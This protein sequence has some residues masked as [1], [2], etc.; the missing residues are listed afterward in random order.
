[1]LINDRIDVHLAAGKWSRFI[2][3]KLQVRKSPLIPG[4][5]GIHIGQTDAPLA[6]ARQMIGDDAII[7]QSVRDVAEAKRAVEGGADYVGIGAVWDTKSKDLKGKKAMGPEGVGEILDM[8]SGT[9]VEAVAIGK[10][11]AAI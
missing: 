1:M 11:V 7:G 3:A 8:L 9:G 2:I 10:T 6:L 4:T 5:A